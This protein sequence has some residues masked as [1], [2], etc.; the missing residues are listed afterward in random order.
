[1]KTTIQ[2][3]QRDCAAACLHM[4]GKYYGFSQQLT[5]Y[6]EMTKTDK[7]GASIYGIIDAAQK[8]GLQGEALNGSIEDL[9]KG[10]ESK[11]IS[12]PL[13]AH[14]V[15]ENNLQH[16]VVVS[17][18][19][20]G[21][22]IIHDPSKGKIKAKKEQF[23]DFWT[24]YIVT[25]K[26][27]KEF[28]KNK[29]SSQGLLRFFKLLGAQYKKIVI[30]IIL[31]IAISIVGIMGAFVFQ[32]VIDNFSEAEVHS[33]INIEESV[34]S[35]V[36]EEHLHDEGSLS[37]G[38]MHFENMNQGMLTS[39]FASLIIM[40][41]LAS[42][43]QYIRGRLIITVSK[44]IDLQLTLPYFFRI[45][46]MPLH[47]VEQRQTGDY[48][49]RFSDAV[50]IRDAISTA[51]LTLVL[52]SLMAIGCG[53]ILFLQNRSLFL[54]SVSVIVAYALVVVSYRKRLLNANRNYME[55]NATVQSYL[56]ETVDGIA[57]IKATVSENAVK[58]RFSNKFNSFIMA[59]VKRGRLGTSLETIVTGAQSVGVAVILWY[60]F[61]LVING[62][63]TI[64]SLITFYALLGYFIEPV[65]N[66]ISLQ[67]TIQSASVTAERLL[68]VMDAET[69]KESD[70]NEELSNINIWEA[71]NVSFRYGNN[72]LTLDKAS[73][74]VKRG[75]KIAIVGESGCGKTTLAKLF[76]RFYNPESGSITADHVPISKYRLSD[77]RKAI[78]YVDQNTFLFSG[79]IRENLLI[80][81]SVVTEEELINACKPAGAYDF[82]MKL[83]FG[84]DTL[85]EENGSNLSGGQ[86]QRLAIA[87]AL[88][89][90][91]QLLILDE[92]TSNLDTVTE[93]GI[94]DTISTLGDSIACIIIAHRLSTV[95]T[96]D[97]IFVM[98]EG[99]IVEFGTHDEL[100]LKGG[101]YAELIRNQ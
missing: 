4:I 20:D 43:I 19:K 47:S 94:K 37:E 99:R 69:E 67:P 54:I 68:D 79:T 23:S 13:I 77:I 73:L 75:E 60:G 46:D 26:K 45:I 31:S 9:L 24:G 48:L 85:I 40:Y 6:R 16:F 30:S 39:I 80:G 21:C 88:L 78:A 11:E 3:D 5:K 59:I 32:L 90:K 25:L 74:S 14:I 22:F 42:L 62:S 76:L 41:L 18:Y 61:S 51:A 35:D 82:I 52:D 7:N 64:G 36:T 97:R 27:T 91:P 65:K 56:K 98:N 72:Q 29:H 44:N 70:G 1:M 100:I 12:L 81:N 58:Q 66:L 50:T 83:P 17:G 71:D 8:I 2:H 93:S 15:T 34:H 55:A 49:S 57:T 63:E 84:F 96:C 95:R 53:F 33:E 38:I 28:K 101:R 87:R 86:K 10:I 92:A 89:V